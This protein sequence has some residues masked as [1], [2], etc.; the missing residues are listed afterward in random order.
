M[1]ISGLGCWV[2]DYIYQ[3]IDFTSEK[4]KQYISKDG[5]NGLVFGE[6]TLISHLVDYFNKSEAAIVEDIGGEVISRNLGG[7]AIITT[8]SAA[9]LLFGNDD[10]DLYFYANLA[11]NELGH[12]VINTL[13]DTPL[14]TDYISMIEGESV[15]THVFCGKDES[16]EVSRTFACA[17]SVHPSTALQLDQL[18]NNFYNSNI[19]IFSCIQWE[20]E[21]CKN[22]SRVLR[23]CKENNSITIVGTANDPLKRGRE[24]W[25]LG[26]SDQVYRYIDFL[27][28]DKAEALYYSGKGTLSAAASFFKSFPIE[29]V[30]ITDG[31]NPTY[32]YSRGCLCSPFEGFIP[33]VRDIV[34]DKMQRLL[35]EGDTVGCGDNFAGGVVASIALQLK[36]KKNQIDLVEA[37]ILGNLSGGI[38]STITGGFYKEKFPGEKKQAIDRYYNK[39]LNQLGEIPI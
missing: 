26:D 21:I 1:I 27:I 5:I 37:C 22:F 30:L 38:T 14:K 19:N 39:Y 33:I 31:I 18:D 6:A 15:F 9:Q 11:D 35:A 17:P 12:F 20:P 25:T 8:V 7:V 10:I 36:R 13:K 4:A 23:K 29:G 24:K 3:N 28:M 2:V 34:K 16:G 32:V